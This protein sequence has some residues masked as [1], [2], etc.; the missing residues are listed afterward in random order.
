MNKQAFPKIVIL[1]DRGSLIT[2]V[3]GTT[4]LGLLRLLFLIVTSAGRRLVV[5]I[6]GHKRHQMALLVRT[7]SLDLMEKVG[8]NFGVS[9]GLSSDLPGKS[10]PELLE[11]PWTSQ[12]FPVSSALVSVS[13]VIA[14]RPWKSKSPWFP[15]L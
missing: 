2:Q 4:L 8:N 7:G 13:Q 6:A 14:R 3:T 11:T 12:N 10:C 15:D 5:A 9:L 1:D